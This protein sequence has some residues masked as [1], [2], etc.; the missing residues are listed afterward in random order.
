MG[1]LPRAAATLQRGAAANPKDPDAWFELGL[2]YMTTHQYSLAE[3]PLRKAIDLGGD[4]RARRQYAS[5]LEKLG[6]LDESLAQWAEILKLRP[7]DLAAQ[8]NYDRVSKLVDSRN[9]KQDQKR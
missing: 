7:N 9:S 3:P 1:Q 5:C 2:Y 4:H 8:Y 6:R